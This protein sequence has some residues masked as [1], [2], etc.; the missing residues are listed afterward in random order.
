[1][2]QHNAVILFSHTPNIDFSNSNGTFPVLPWEDIDALYTAMIGDFVKNACQVQSVDVLLYRNPNE[3]SDDFFL[4]YQQRL[5]LFDL[6]DLPLSEQIQQAVENAFSS[7]YQN[8][9]VVLDNHT[10]ITRAILRRVL[11]QLGY[12]DDCLVVGPTFDE[13]C[14][15]VGMKMNHGR[16]FDTSEGELLYKPMILLK[17]ICNIDSMLFLLNPI[18]SLDTPANLMDLMKHIDALDKANVEFPTK[19]YAVFKMFEKKYKL[20]KLLQ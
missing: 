17:H 4:P 18:N 5:Q 6:T 20:K 1:M 13:K 3:L 15:L 12:E 19:T 14:Y 10:M 8:V 9:I 11:S 7:G 2:P 16:I